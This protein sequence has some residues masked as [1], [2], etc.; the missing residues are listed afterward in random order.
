[1]I[2]VHFYIRSNVTGLHFGA[3]KAK[4][5]VLWNLQHSKLL[6]L[7]LMWFICVVVSLYLPFGI[8]STSTHLSHVALEFY[9]PKRMKN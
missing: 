7:S 3:K 6:Q 8:K 1:M 2:I 4:N 5:R 9:K